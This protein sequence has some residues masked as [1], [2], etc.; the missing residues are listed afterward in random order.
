MDKVPEETE[1]VDSRLSHK[2]HVA[3]LHYE[4]LRTQNAQETVVRLNYKHARGENTRDQQF[5]GLH[6]A[7]D[8][9]QVQHR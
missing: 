2:R 1:K 3:K 6:V 8:M 7:E 9:L 5:A 4:L